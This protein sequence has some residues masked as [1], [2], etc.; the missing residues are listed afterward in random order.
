MSEN[1][2]F[3]RVNEYLLRYAKPSNS[4]RGKAAY[5]QTAIFPMF[6]AHF[7]VAEACKTSL[8]KPVLVYLVYLF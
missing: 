6:L 7:T 8:A 3:S 5:L 1:P 4:G 2:G